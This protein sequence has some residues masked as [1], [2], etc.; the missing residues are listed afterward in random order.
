LLL[1]LLFTIFTIQ[2]TWRALADLL[3]VKWSTNVSEM[4]A[5][6]LEGSLSAM[7]TRFPESFPVR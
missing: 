4:L 1:T 7:A 6:H 2:R 3:I 5:Q